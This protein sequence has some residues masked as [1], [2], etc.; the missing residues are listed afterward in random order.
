[1]DLDEFEE[2]SSDREEEVE[3]PPQQE[4]DQAPDRIVYRFR[5]FT[6]QLSFAKSFFYTLA[7]GT[8]LPHETVVKHKSSGN[9][10]TSGAFTAIFTEY[11]LKNRRS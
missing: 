7:A 8:P 4:Y 2:A 6:D 1:M 11:L 10:K 9:N 5:V 3:P